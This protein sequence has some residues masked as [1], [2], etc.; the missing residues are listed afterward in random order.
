VNSAIVPT[1]LSMAHY[2]RPSPSP[3]MASASSYASIVEI[4]LSAKFVQ[5]NTIP[6]G[7]VIAPGAHFVKSWKLVNDGQAAWPA[8]ARLVFMGGETFGTSP[9]LKVNVAGEVREVKPRDCVDLD[10][11]FT[12]PA[13]LGRHLSHWGMDD[14]E[15]LK[16]GHRLW[17]EIEVA[18]P[19]EK[20]EHASLSSSTVVMPAPASIASPTAGRSP[21]VISRSVVRGTPTIS[22]LPSEVDIDEVNDNDTESDVS[23]I[24][25]DAS[26]ATSPDEFVMIYDSVSE[27]ESDG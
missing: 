20:S 21:V 2:A 9:D 12:A 13:T 15:G 4:P 23:G 24:W 18:E 22:S 19:L 27:G 8:K 3:S 17:C 10:V 26:R 11:E 25:E 16:F 1:S 7:F 14:G 5:D 6:D